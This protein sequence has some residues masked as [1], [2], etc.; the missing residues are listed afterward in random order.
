M[1]SMKPI[2]A[3]ALACALASGARAQPS[4]S[5]EWRYYG[6]DQGGMKYS[7]IDQINRQNVSSLQTAWTWRTGEKAR[8]DLNVGPGAFDATPIM[9]EDVVYVSTPFNRVVALDATSGRSGPTIPKP[10]T[11]ARSRGQGFVHRGIAAWR[12]GGTLR[13]FLNS[14]YR[15]ICLD[16]KTGLPVDCRR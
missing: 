9:I 6:G 8:P 15:L 16:A 4:K 10:T 3:V 14:R 2:L 13:I 1:N 7:P 12:D 5:I 11:P